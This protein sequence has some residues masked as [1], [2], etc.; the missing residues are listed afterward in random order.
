L[1]T[2]SK[3]LV[4]LIAESQKIDQR[5]LKFLTKPLENPGARYTIYK[6]YTHQEDNPIVVSYIKKL[7]KK[8]QFDVAL[9]KT[10]KIEVEF[11]KNNVLLC[12]LPQLQGT[13]RL[14]A[15]TMGS[16]KTAKYPRHWKDI[17]QSIFVPP[18]LKV[19]GKIDPSLFFQNLEKIR[20]GPLI[21]L[22]VFSNPKLTKVE[23]LN[24]E[25]NTVGKSDHMVTICKGEKDDWCQKVEDMTGEQALKGLGGR[26][27]T[28]FTSI[29]IPDGFEVTLVGASNIIGPVFG[30]QVLREPCGGKGSY[31]AIIAKKTTGSAAD[32]VIVCEEEDFKGYC[33]QL[34]PHFMGSSSATSDDTGAIKLES[35]FPIEES[36]L[37]KYKNDKKL[38][39]CG[40][41]KV[42]SIK[43]PAAYT[44]FLYDAKD[45]LNGPWS[46]PLEMSSIAGD[47]IIK[48]LV[49][50]N[51]NSKSLRRD[52]IV[53][54]SPQIAP[55][56]E[57]ME[58]LNNSS[59]R[60]YLRHHRHHHHVRRID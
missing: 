39:T 5:V 11:D 35:G 51:I 30:H 4:N 6:L 10:V 43:V 46:G 47:G 2:L 18:G 53:D 3:G 36:A 44:L 58:M 20:F 48:A 37:S 38:K 34:S 16:A 40:V 21:G 1:L 54:I 55:D 24:V 19:T 28:S 27:F 22:G 12:N 31:N 32:R 45:V 59:K 25:K 52:D 8:D 26:D 57:D 49:Q 41:S 7:D 9:D 15:E 17:T 50:P 23:E 14:F 42:Q 56:T 33:Q 13:C 60:H 29:L